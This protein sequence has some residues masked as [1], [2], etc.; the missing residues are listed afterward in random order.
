MLKIGGHVA[1]V[2]PL[3][4]VEN[5][6][7]FTEEIL[8]GMMEHLGFQKIESHTSK[9]LC[10]YFYEKKEEVIFLYFVEILISENKTHEFQVEYR[11]GTKPKFVRKIV[12][13]GGERNNFSI[14]L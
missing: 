4:C 12:K 3:P 11:P 9:K 2:L 6:R 5:S 7:Y 1:I 14:V 10:Y 8:A 13:Q